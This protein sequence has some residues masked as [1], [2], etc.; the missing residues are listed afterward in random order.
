[1]GFP[2]RCGRATVDGHRAVSVT[3]TEGIVNNFDNNQPLAIA[4]HRCRRPCRT[5]G[6]R[7]G[8]MC[9]KYHKRG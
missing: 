7:G 6:G 8:T 5:G 1:M 2:S 4:R 3:H 9:S